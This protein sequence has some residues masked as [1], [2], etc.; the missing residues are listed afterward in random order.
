MPRTLRSSTIQSSSPSGSSSTVASSQSP[1]PSVSRQAPKKAKGSATAKPNNDNI[2]SIELHLARGALPHWQKPFR[3]LRDEEEN[4]IIYWG[5]NVSNSAPSVFVMDCDTYEGEDITDKLSYLPGPDGETNKGLPGLKDP[6]VVLIKPES[7]E[8]FLVIFGGEV[9]GMGLGSSK[10]Y[11]VD[12]KRRQWGEI[13]PEDDSPPL[14]RVGAAACVVGSSFYMFG[15][16]VRGS[17]ARSYTVGR[18]SLEKETARLRCEW[19]YMDMAYPKDTPYAG[20]FGG[21]VPLDGGKYILLLPGGNSRSVVEF[22]KAEE[23]TLYDTAENNPEEERFTRIPSWQLTTL[24][25]AIWYNVMPPPATLIDRLPEFAIPGSTDPC[26]TTFLIMVL[27][28][29]SENGHMAYLW[30]V[31]VSPQTGTIKVRKLDVD[32][33]QKRI[34]RQRKVDMFAFFTTAGKLAFLGKKGNKQVKGSSYVADPGPHVPFGCMLSHRQIALKFDWHGRSQS[35][36]V[37]LSRFARFNLSPL[38]PPSLIHSMA[39]TLRRSERQAASLSKVSSATNVTQPKAPR[40]GRTGSRKPKGKVAEE[41]KMKA[42]KKAKGKAAI[43]PGQSNER[44]NITRVELHPVVG[45]V[46]DLWHPFRTLRD[47]AGNRIIYWGFNPSTGTSTRTTSIFIL[48]GDSYQSEDITV[49][50]RVLISKDPLFSPS[51]SRWKA[52]LNYRPSEGEPIKR[53]LPDLRDP[54]VVL[55]KPDTGETF[56]VIF[57]GEVQGMGLG[58]SKLYY[59]DIKRREWG[60]IQPE[61]NSTPPLPRVGAAACVIDSTFYM[62]GGEIRGSPARSYTVGRLSF[63]REVKQLRCD[64]VQRDTKYPSHIPFAGYFGGCVLLDGG[65]Y[66]LLLPGGSSDPEMDNAMTVNFPKERELTLYNTDVKKPEPERFTRISSGRYRT[67]KMH[68]GIT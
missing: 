34:W 46:H 21:C 28:T 11:Y 5:F 33:A 60:E 18:L 37:P 1:A 41:A 27:P 8:N 55:A 36:A 52:E 29:T 31:C 64:W 10:L 56:L 65:K 58:N 16:E 30:A 62:F 42:T 53:P 4:H 61:D 63:H 19:V 49:R 40:R 25:A 12:M 7:G 3:T 26:P 44:P 35:C 17:R 66:I 22:N 20:Y 51:S 50:A 54:S 67:S 13:P 59:V 57:G 9:L 15:G 24:P 2:E 23:L 32:K 45:K 14:P 43:G 68:R 39:P 38:P 48:D 47:E 6:S